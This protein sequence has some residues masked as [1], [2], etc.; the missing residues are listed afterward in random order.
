MA[1][2]SAAAP[3]APG[4]SGVMD[5][6]LK[7]GAIG[8]ISNIVIGVASTAPAYSLATTL[9]VDRRRQGVG[10]HAPAVLL[11]AFIPMLLVASRLQI[12]QPRRP[13]R[14]HDVRVDDARA[15][16]DDGLD[17]RL[18]DLP[19]RRD[20]DGLALGHRRDL[21]V[22][23]LRLHRTR[24][25]ESRDH[26]RRGP[27]DRADDVDLLPRH[28]ALGAH[29]GDPARRRGRDPRLFSVVAFVKVYSGSPPARRR[30]SPSAS[31]VQPVR[32]EL[33]RPDRSRCC[34]A[35]SSTGAGIRASRSTRSPRTRP[36]ARAR[37][38]SSRR[39]CSS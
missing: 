28:R 35:S 21:H 39:S 6:G 10:I 17:E 19:R 32:D 31:L 27:V 16:A 30:S 37:R 4:I 12:P 14:R 38:R 29:P 23:A 13:R 34:S 18:G 7:K 24:R 26:H 2:E 15:R 11:V 25:I 33:Q 22:Q 1:T 3:G 5:K 36:R 8:Y 20:R 9:G